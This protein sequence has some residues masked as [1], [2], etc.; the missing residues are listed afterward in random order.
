MLGQKRS[1]FPLKREVVTAAPEPHMYI[2]WLQAVSHLALIPPDSINPHPIPLP[3]AW[4][5]IAAD[6][7]NLPSVICAAVNR[8]TTAAA[9]ALPGRRARAIASKAVGC[10]GRLLHAL[11]RRKHSSALSGAGEWRRAFPALFW[12]VGGI[13]R[14]SRR[15]Q[16]AGTPRKSSACCPGLFWYRESIAVLLSDPPA[17]SLQWVQHLHPIPRFPTYFLLEPSCWSWSGGA[18]GMQAAAARLQGGLPL[19]Q[20][21]CRGI[22]PGCRNG[23]CQPK[24]LPSLHIHCWFICT[25]SITEAKGPP[26]SWETFLCHDELRAARSFVNSHFLS[27]LQ[28]ISCLNTGDWKSSGLLGL[29]SVVIRDF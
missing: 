22:L 10:T 1:G 26:E 14:R 23:R 5:K 7:L 12:E 28:Y 13:I 8:G 18:G 3:K 11:L 16:W 2:L 15:E 24:P 21:S 29:K 17:I 25:S 9:R 4:S 19:L 27:T 20:N 6:D